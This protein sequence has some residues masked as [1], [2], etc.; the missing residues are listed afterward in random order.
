MQKLKI[1]GVGLLVISLPLLSGLAA[2]CDTIFY[3]FSS[4]GFLLNTEITNFQ[5]FFSVISV[6]SSVILLL[7]NYVREKCEIVRLAH[8]NKIS[9]SLIKDIFLSK[10]ETT[11]K[12]ENMNLSIRIFLPDTSLIYLLKKR[13][14]PNRRKLYF[15]I[16]D[17]PAFAENSNMTKDLR[18]M[19]FPNQEGLVGK[20]FN[21]R[22]LQWD[23]NLE[24]TN[25][26][27]YNLSRW[28]KNKTSDLRFII[29]LPIVDDK[30]N[31]V[32]IFALDTKSN[33]IIEDCDTVIKQL[34]KTMITLGQTLYQEIPYLFR[35]SK[36]R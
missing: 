1:F 8:D 6:V 12:S 34:E 21:E 33:I 22:K 32:A 9:L 25:N 16:K 29:C 2:N 14:L 10:I 35:N 31:I 11:L 30:D 4:H 27:D 26:T 15:K 28:Q 23:V 17:I 13:F 20:C 24:N 5:D 36:W 19:V 3:Y 18:F 7:Y